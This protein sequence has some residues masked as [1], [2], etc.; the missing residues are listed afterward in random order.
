[1]NLD[2]HFLEMYQQDVLDNALH[3]VVAYAHQSLTHQPVTSVKRD[4]VTPLSVQAYPNPFT[5]ETIL[6]TGGVVS[7][8]T[9]RVYDTLGQEMEVLNIISGQEIR[10][11]RENL[12]S[13]VYFICLTQSRAAVP[14]YNVIITR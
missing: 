12:P 8:A 1:V 14:R 11:K 7:N 5:T 13:G 6:H 3:W 2:S 9:L 4:A 10:I